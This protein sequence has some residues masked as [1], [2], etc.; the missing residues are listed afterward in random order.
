MKRAK[1]IGVRKVSG[2]SGKNLVFQFLFESIFISISG[3]VLSIVLILILLPYFDAFIGKPLHV[4]GNLLL[5]ILGCAIAL[6]ILS[7][8]YPAF[9][10]SRYKPA[11][12]LK[13]KRANTKEGHMFR[14][15]LVTIQLTVSAVLL[16]ASWVIQNQLGYIQNTNPGYS[17]DQVITLNWRDSRIKDYWQALK[18]EITR[19]P[20]VEIVSVGSQL[21]NSITSQ[22]TRRWLVNGEEKTIGFYTNYVDADFIPLLDIKLLAGRN[23]KQGGEGEGNNYILNE[24]AVKELGLEDPIGARFIQNGTDTVTIIGVVKDFHFASMHQQIAPMRLRIVDNWISRVM[25]KFNTQNL[26]EIIWNLEQVSRK[27]APDY[28][29]DYGFL[30]DQF[31]QVYAQDK[32]TETIV[33]FLTITALSLASLGLL[34]LITFVTSQRYKEVGIRKVFGARRVNLVLLLTSKLNGILLMS[35]FVAV[36]IAYYL[37]SSWLANFVYKIDLKTWPFIASFIILA[38][39]VWSTVLLKILRATRVNPIQVLRYE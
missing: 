14:D 20:S 8:I 10:L 5:F 24:T 15:I 7:G 1:E 28:P 2:A 30:D 27:F 23:F 36:P 22:Q 6:G 26:E 37:M 31:M 35:F 17:R 4:N 3:L 9:L 33:K 12:V 13:G 11:T 18:T 38:V 25:V 19:I 21:P 29:F 32:K 39:I 34:G 16:I